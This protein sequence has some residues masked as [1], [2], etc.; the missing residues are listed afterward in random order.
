MRDLARDG[1]SI[2]LVTHQLDE[3]IPEI[4]RVVLLAGG[5]IVADGPKAEVFTR[6]RLGALFG[7]PVE[8]ELR[9]GV[10]VAY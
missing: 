8:V 3:V 5:R 7:V 10:Y 2:V 6:E 9:D 1:V 4:D